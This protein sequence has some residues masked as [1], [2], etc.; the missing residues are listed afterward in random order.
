M[1]PVIMC[2]WIEHVC[3]TDDRRIA[4]GKWV[5]AYT[6][7]IESEMSRI[8]QWLLDSIIEGMQIWSLRCI[9]VVRSR[10]LICIR[11][12]RRHCGREMLY[13][14]YCVAREARS[15][16]ICNFFLKNEPNL[17]V[18]RNRQGRIVYHRV[19]CNCI[20]ESRDGPDGPLRL[21][22]NITPLYDSRVYKHLV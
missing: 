14:V 11:Q 5:E 21:K 15:S 22:L 7:A 18:L 8:D 9:N 19:S 3:W 6:A 12:G 13:V 2:D 16:Y 10:S 17:R 20:R 4:A 1:P